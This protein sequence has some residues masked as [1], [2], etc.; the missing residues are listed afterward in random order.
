LDAETTPYFSAMTFSFTLS[1]C[2][3]FVHPRQIHRGLGAGGAN[4]TRPRCRHGHCTP[5]NSGESSGPRS[6]AV[7]AKLQSNARPRP[8]RDRGELAGEAKKRGAA[9]QSRDPRD[10]TITEHAREIARWTHQAE[11]AEALVEVPKNIAACPTS[12][13]LRSWA[14]RC[15]QRRCYLGVLGPDTSQRDASAGE[16]WAPRH[17]R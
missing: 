10:K 1:G 6:I 12:G 4:P 16:D 15:P 11:R 2:Y 5:V 13:H 7:C 9:P 17:M 8:A 14:V 3:I